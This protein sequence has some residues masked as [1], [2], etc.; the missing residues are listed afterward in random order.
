MLS[1]MF[2]LRDSL[3]EGASFYNDNTVPFKFMDE[4][5]CFNEANAIISETMNDITSFSYEGQS[6]II[7]NASNPRVDILTEGFFASFAEKIKKFFE[8]MKKLFLGIYDRIRAYAAKLTGNTSKWLQVMTPRIKAKKTA[9]G[10]NELEYSVLKPEIDQS[11]ATGAPI[12][13]FVIDEFNELYEACKNGGIVDGRDY[14]G[15]VNK[16][17]IV[18]KKTAQLI[19]QCAKAAGMNSSADT[20]DELI[21]D[22]SDMMFGN[23]EDVK[24]ASA[25]DE[26]LE[27]IKNSNKI[28][29]DITKS[30]KKVIDEVDK[31]KR[32]MDS[33]SSK[34]KSNDNAPDVKFYAG[35]STKNPTQADFHEGDTAK[36]MRTN[37]AAIFEAY[38]TVCSNTSKMFNGFKNIAV[39]FIK[40]SINDYMNALT[41]MAYFKEKKPA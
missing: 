8:N 10:I 3:T 23:K 7:E 36:K 28:I 19:D 25:A 4:N 9:S 5:T 34:L 40:T 18:E 2:A 27:A 41:K 20:V 33:M 16:E 37:L 1:S 15:D 35:L 31:C 26:M 12:E 24:V 17:E 39:K 14:D 32:N 6:L 29:N 13:N 11:K 30:Y 38:S 21:K 22:F